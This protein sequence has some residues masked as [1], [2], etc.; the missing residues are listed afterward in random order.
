ML[1]P[2]L[3]LSEH[4]I[5]VTSLAVDKSSQ[6][7]YWLDS[8]ERRLEVANTDGTNRRVLFSGMVNPTGLALDPKS[9]YVVC[10][11]VYILT[12][13]IIYT[14]IR[15]CILTYIRMC[16]YVTYVYRNY[17]VYIWMYIHPSVRPPSIHSCIHA[18]TYVRIYIYVHNYE[19]Y[20]YMYINLSIYISFHPSP[21]HPSIHQAHLPTTITIYVY[22]YMYIHT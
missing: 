9:M 8:R 6:H 1:T 14:C 21:I 2:E 20:T 11:C 13:I 10:V 17:E 22:M 3:I 15:T 7:I 19:I 18:Y 16:T 5:T 4:P 12:T